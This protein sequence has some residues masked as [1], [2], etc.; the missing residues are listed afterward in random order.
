MSFSLCVVESLT[1]NRNL[2]HFFL[3]MILNQTPDQSLVETTS[4]RIEEYIKTKLSNCE[5]I[6]PLSE[7]LVEMYDPMQL[8]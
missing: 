8:D 1:I 3:F 6:P 2:I 7:I 4:K 5:T